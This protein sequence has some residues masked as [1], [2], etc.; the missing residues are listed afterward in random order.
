MGDAM[1]ANDG[2]SGTRAALAA[3][4]GAVIAARPLVNLT[5]PLGVGKTWL[6][7]ALDA[8][9]VDLSRPH[10]PGDLRRA[11]T[12]DDRRPLVLDGVDGRTAMESAAGALDDAP[13]GHRPV[14]VLSRRPLRAARGWAG[15]DLVTLAV[16]P[17]PDNEIAAL[18]SRAGL[19]DPG[20]RDLVVRLA[21]GIPLVALAACRAMHAGATPTAP[22]AVAD[23]VSSEILQR[24]E[25]ELP[26]R[27]R[28]QAL[29]LLAAVGAADEKLL[30]K[31]P[32]LFTDLAGLSL[33]HR[34]ALG[35]TVAEPYR[36]LLDMTYQWRRP[37]QHG[38][39]LARAARYRGAMLTESAP[40]ERRAE[41][42]EQS[43][44]LAGDRVVRE[45]LFPPGRPP[46]PIVTA[47][48]TDADD[49]GR[50]MHG[51]ASLKGF[52]Q[53]RTERPVTRWL[54]DDITGFRLARDIDGQPIGLISLIGVREQTLTG[55]EPLLQQH[56]ERLA[57]GD[58][59]GLFL[60]AAFCPEPAVHAQVLRHILRQAVTS[61]RLL[62]STADPGYHQLL[63]SLAFRRHGGIHD[64]IYRCGRA[65]QVYSNDFTGAALPAWLRRLSATATDTAGE[66]AAAHVTEALSNLHTAKGLAGSPLLTAAH[67]PTARALRAWLV[68][69]VDALAA[70]LSAADADAGRVLR[71]YYV[72]RSGTHWQVA[73]SLHLSRATY[74]RRLRRGV[75]ALAAQHDR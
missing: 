54:D 20:A 45:V 11:V 16:P 35:L 15:G 74:F 1:G 18:A 27:R 25:R 10:T 32:D 47:Q 59:G 23:E 55:M 8:Q 58:R 2:D 68:E 12:G 73:H 64:D 5:G 48:G 52:D 69:A 44:L 63:D 3:E 28:A 67:T 30:A 40:P 61:G 31:G 6:A 41:L 29:R 39:L 22:A 71:A 60:G 56:T 53:H 24:L 26:G 51:W 36:A 34:T 7:H 21:G 19:A 33:V 70:S 43:M 75:T 37:D 13:A 62:V 38:A 4:L 72:D 46:V 17:L 42:S 14:L 50:L 66:T 57:A 65:P 9:H 49:I